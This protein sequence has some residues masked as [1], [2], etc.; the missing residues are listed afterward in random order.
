M[1]RWADLLRALLLGLAIIAAALLHG[2]LYDARSAG[3]RLYV[4]HRWTGQVTHCVPT[5]CNSVPHR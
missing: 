5:F 4:V 1:E 3:E 2:G